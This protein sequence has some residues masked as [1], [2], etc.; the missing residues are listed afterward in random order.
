MQ[1][2]TEF[3]W[4]IIVFTGVVLFVGITLM[5]EYIIELR[6][7]EKRNKMINKIR[8]HSKVTFYIKNGYGEK[9]EITGH[10]TRVNRKGQ[11][12]EI[13]AGDELYRGV[14]LVRV[15]NIITV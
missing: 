8:R 14:D 11:F 10:V 1:Y 3:E 9:E 6:A 2:Q 12:C 7:D 15:V 5:V 4:T 13:K